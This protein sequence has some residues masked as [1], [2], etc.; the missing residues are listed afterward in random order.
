MGAGEPVLIQTRVDR[1]LSSPK[2]VDV[3]TIGSEAGRDLGTDGNGPVAGDHDIDA[4]RSLIRGS[5]CAVAVPP[6]M[7]MLAGTRTLVRLDLLARSWDV[8][9]HWPRLAGHSER[10]S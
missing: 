10:P 4:P 2:R 7:P 6:T 9:S 3:G 1:F 8:D 5:N